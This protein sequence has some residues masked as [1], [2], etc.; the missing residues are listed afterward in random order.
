MIKL[1]SSVSIVG[2][3]NIQTQ[4]NVYRDQFENGYTRQTNRVCLPLARAS[5]VLL[6]CSED[7]YN[8]FLAFWK[9]AYNGAAWFTFNNPEKSGET[10]GRI[11]SGNYNS[12]RINAQ[13]NA[14]EVSFEIEY[15]L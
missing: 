13:Y 9:S 6:C 5:I 3:D 15:Y 1:P 10:R 8:D 14:H 4:D 2:F 11:I 12:K 7:C